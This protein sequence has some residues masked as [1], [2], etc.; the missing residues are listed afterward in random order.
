MPLTLLLADDHRL[1]RE[2][3]RAL[4][5]AVPDFKL[6]GEAA[7]G[8]ETVRLTERLRPQVLILDLL[9]PGMSG[10]EVARQ[11]SQRTPETHIVVLSMHAHEAYVT[12]A[13]RAG[14]LA[15]VA[16]DASAEELIQAVRSAAAGRPYVGT[17]PKP[18]SPNELTARERE[19]LQLTAEGYSSAEVG[20]HLFISPRTVESHRANL[21]RKLHLRNQRE[22]VRYAVEHNLVPNEQRNIRGEGVPRSD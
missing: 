11:V 9:M 14:A 13:T 3:L 2:G 15:Y 4:L 18:S 6:V 1:V 21:M 17:A 12:E 16:K 7:D 22:L 5:E 10:L 20:R 19:V 8:P